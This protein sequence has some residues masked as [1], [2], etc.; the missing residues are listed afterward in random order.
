M[1]SLL[2]KSRWWL[3]WSC[4]LPT[5]SEPSVKAAIQTA[6]II[7][8]LCI[9]TVLLLVAASLVRPPTLLLAALLC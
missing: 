3:A 2:P 7:A 9:S 1:T 5:I 4:C 6:V 8:T